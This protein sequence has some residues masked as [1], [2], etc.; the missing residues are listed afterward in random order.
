[1]SIRRAV[2]T[3][4]APGQNSLP[5]QNVVDRDGI[6]KTAL[7]LILE[8]IVDAGIDEI[9]VVICPGDESNYAAAAGEHV[10]RITF[11]EQSNPRGYG[12]A[13]FRARDF[14]GDESFLHLVGDHL[15][16]SR[17]ERGCARQLVDVANAESCAVSAV[18]ATRESLLPYFGAIS[19]KRISGRQD[20]YDITNVIEKP[21][22]T[23]AEQELIVAGLRSSHYLCLFG[24]HVLTPG[25]L[26]DLERALSLTPPE[27]PVLL[28]PA[29]A[30]MAT[31]ER[32]LALQ[33]EG[34]RYNIGVKYGLLMAQLAVALSGKDREQILTEILELVATANTNLEAVQ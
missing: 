20:L 13:I 26:P 21:T 11:V 8:E 28:S 7:Q 1:M 34:S 19:A 29:L 15:Y 10:N 32:Y 33:I 3:A 22:P 24:M 2:V 27:L 4:A 31:R 14:I 18:Q 5:L 30:S 17:T 9:C 23:Q 12:D 25:I 6:N 16:L